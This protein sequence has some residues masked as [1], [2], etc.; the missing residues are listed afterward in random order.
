MLKLTKFLLVL[1]VTSLCL[2]QISCDSAEDCVTQEVSGFA[3]SDISY[4]IQIG[5]FSEE[6]NVQT[7]PFFDALAAGTNVESESVTNADGDIITRYYAGGELAT[8][9]AALDYLDTIDEDY[10]DA[11]MVA[12]G[13]STTRIGEVTD[14]MKASLCL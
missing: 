8:Y 13:S 5:A 7:D 6:K 1:F 12:F 4:R 9:Q 14:A 11:F 2:V 10:T 3:A